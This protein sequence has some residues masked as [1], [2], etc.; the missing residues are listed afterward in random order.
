VAYNTEQLGGDQPDFQ[1]INK[2][3]GMNIKPK[4]LQGIQINIEF[5]LR[6]KS[7]ERFDF[8]WPGGSWDLQLSGRLHS[9]KFG[10]ALRG[11][12]Q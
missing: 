12:V 7:R 2:D 10:T 1:I 4:S 5:F 3:E 11:E 8:R 6:F 9:H